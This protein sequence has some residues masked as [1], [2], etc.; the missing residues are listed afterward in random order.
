MTGASWTEEA[1]QAVNDVASHLVGEI[2]RSMVYYQ[3]RS[4][5][6][7]VDKILLC[8][9]SSRLR[10]LREMIE[11]QLGTPVEPWS[12]MAGVHV[13]GGRFDLPS[14]E[15]L[16]PFVALATALAMRSEVA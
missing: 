14:V 10:G 13:D 8:G 2:H 1:E 15:Q 4:H 9:G 6:A 16:S 3:T 11:K 5:G 12:P 7:K